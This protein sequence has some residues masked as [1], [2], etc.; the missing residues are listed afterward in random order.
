MGADFII[1][2]HVR[3]ETQGYELTIVFVNPDRG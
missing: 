2:P 1:V 3:D